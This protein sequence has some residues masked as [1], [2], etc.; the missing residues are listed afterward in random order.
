MSTCKYCGQKAGFF[1][2]VH[3]EC[4]LLHFNGT[5]IIVN[6]IYESLKTSANLQV[7]ESEIK[8][9]QESSFILPSEMSDL[10]VLA[11]D[12]TM[13]YFLDDGVISTE[14]ETNI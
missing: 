12:K 13:N 3:S 8:N 6:G 14:E 10:Y 9:T 4:E 7:L 2:K 11:F 5:T 1:K